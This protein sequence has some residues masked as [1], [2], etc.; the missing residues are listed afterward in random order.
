MR[1]G[2]SSSTCAL[3]VIV[4]FF[5]FFLFFLLFSNPLFTNLQI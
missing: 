4:L 2:L 3:F 1:A 5:L